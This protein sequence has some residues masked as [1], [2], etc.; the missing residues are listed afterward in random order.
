M[1]QPPAVISEDDLSERAH[2]EVVGG[3]ACLPGEF[4]KA[5]PWQ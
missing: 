3:G 5:D 1:T 2:L 4:R